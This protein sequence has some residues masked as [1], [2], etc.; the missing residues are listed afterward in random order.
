M[1][2]SKESEPE[3]LSTLDGDALAALL[4][5]VKKRLVDAD[6]RKSIYSSPEVDAMVAADRAET[7]AVLDECAL[8]LLDPGPE[9]LRAQILRDDVERLRA[10]VRAIVAKGPNVATPTFSNRF[11]GRCDACT[12]LLGP[13]TTTAVAPGPR[14]SPKPRSC[15][16]R[17]T[18]RPHS[19]APA[20]L[21]RADAPRPRS[22]PHGALGREVDQGPARSLR[23][24]AEGSGSQGSRRADGSER[25]LGLAA[26]GGS[27]STPSKGPFRLGEW[28]AR[29][30]YLA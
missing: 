1:S 26:R 22:H 5:T 7:E 10:A 29:L 6:L 4:A 3:D 12:A 2:E 8:R 23:R 13:A 17:R 27:P 20:H 25:A 30:R 11:S 28:R 19:V 24:A 15:D 9:H 21:P 14:S 16:R 18:P